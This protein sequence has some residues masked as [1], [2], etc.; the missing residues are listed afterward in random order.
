MAPARA[1]PPATLLILASERMPRKQRAT[2]E[3]PGSW[4]GRA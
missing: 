3:R 2:R 1:A 4:R